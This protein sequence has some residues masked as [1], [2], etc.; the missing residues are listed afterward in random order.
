MLLIAVATEFE[1]A[2]LRERLAERD[3]IACIVTGVGPVNA[4]HAVT[5]AVTQHRPTAVMVCGVGGAYPGS[6]LGVGD[7]VC[8]GT[9]CYGDLGASSPAGFIDMHSLGFPVVRVEP[10][11]YNDL[12]MQIVPLDRSVKFVTVSTCT[13]TDEA[14]RAIESR[15]GGAVENMEGAAIAHVGRLMGV[16]VGEIRA[17]SNVVTNR[18]TKTWRLREAAT[19]AQEALLAWIDSR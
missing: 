9:E 11:L 3:G 10:P 5:L 12:P 6:G 1:T 14:A 17:I 18:D 2:L 8:A 16:P 13:G 7:V 19:A 4:A 15:T